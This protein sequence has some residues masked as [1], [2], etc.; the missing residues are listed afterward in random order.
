MNILPKIYNDHS[1]R[2]K[3]IADTLKITGGFG[4]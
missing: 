4:E 2:R 3:F 1:G